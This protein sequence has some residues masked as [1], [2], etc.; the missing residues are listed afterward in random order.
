MGRHSPSPPPSFAVPR[1]VGRGLG[2]CPFRNAGW[3]DEEEDDEED[4]EGADCRRTSEDDPNRD[5]TAAVDRDRS[6]A[7]IFDY[8]AC[9]AGLACSLR[10]EEGKRWSARGQ[11][12]E[13]E[14]R[15]QIGSAA[16][17]RCS[18]PTRFNSLTYS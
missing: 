12:H 5:R 18:V 3:P 2:A 8:S 4:D 6:E 16:P 11:V 13:S 17:L 9:D 7:D 14:P 1:V 10:R 15:R